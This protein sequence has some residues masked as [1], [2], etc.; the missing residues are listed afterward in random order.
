MRQHTPGEE[1]RGGTGAKAEAARQAKQLVDALGRTLAER[2]A[3]SESLSLSPPTE[4]ATHPEGRCFRLSAKYVD[5]VFPSRY[6][7]STLALQLA[8]HRSDGGEERWE[9][10]LT[11]L[12][13]AMDLGPA[14]G[15][16]P[17]GS[18]PAAADSILSVLRGGS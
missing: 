15:S 9:L 14:H 18:P 12:G 17:G 8:L 11:D 13:R 10:T 3:P 16:E 1:D 6:V 4:D 7:D 5:I 2:L